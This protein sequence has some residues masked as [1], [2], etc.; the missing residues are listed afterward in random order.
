MLI[1]SVLKTQI[2][3]LCV[4]VAPLKDNSQVMARVR[5]SP[6]HVSR[7]EPTR[8]DGFLQEEM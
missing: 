4:F 6:G 5:V 7:L 8:S 2:L 1:Y 3:R